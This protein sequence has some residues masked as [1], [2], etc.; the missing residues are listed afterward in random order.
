MVLRVSLVGEVGIQNEGAQVAG[1][2]LGRLGRI[3]LAYLVSERGRPVPHAELAEVLWGEDLPRSWE[4][5]VR[6]TAVKLRAALREVGLE[7]A[8]VLVT[9]FGCYEFRLPTDASVDVET[10]FA[11]VDAASA[12]L[13]G[14]DHERAQAE[15]E[16]AL[17]IT[18]R[19]FVPGGAGLWV[20]RRQAELRELHLHAARGPC[21]RGDRRPPL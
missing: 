17:R 8:E 16:T 2:S 20:E 15:A 14:R 4:Q 7:P 13:E 6:G 3:A 12:A 18:A 5:L 10:A 19:Q 1:K 11:S 9:K 21:R